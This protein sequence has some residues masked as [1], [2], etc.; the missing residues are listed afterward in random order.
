MLFI[1]T[2]L[3]LLSKIKEN[4]NASENSVSFNI[5][6][7][8]PGFGEI[9]GALI[10]K[11]L[12]SNTWSYKIKG[13]KFLDKNGVRVNNIFNKVQGL[14]EWTIL[15]LEN[16]KQVKF[17]LKNNT[18]DFPNNQTAKIVIDKDK[19]Y[20]GKDIK[21]K[22][23]NSMLEVI[24]PNVYLFEVA[25]HKSVIFDSIEIL[26][27]RNEGFVKAKEHNLI[28]DFIPISTIY[29]PVTNVTFDVQNRMIDNIKVDLLQI[30]I[31]TDGTQTPKEC[32][33][34]VLSIINTSFKI[35]LQNILPKT[36]KK[37]KN[38]M[39]IAPNSFDIENLQLSTRLKNCLTRL[40]INNI[41]EFCSNTTETEAK[42]I[43]DLGKKTFEELL[44]FM[45]E[46]DLN[47]KNENKKK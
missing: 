41:I 16:L 6:N 22:D 35:L 43:K 26:I 7:I 27:D 3:A 5:S 46:K 21:F 9:Y 37:G 29:C 30:D 2:K 24:N 1:S 39:Y 33:I 45:K 31:E 40:K 4:E 34:V 10:R 38:M 19:S 11:L 15:I 14:Y 32:L 44:K 23:E 18:Q 36:E 25:D 12:F 47:F 8:M 42:N 13:V 20:S 17:K 28:G